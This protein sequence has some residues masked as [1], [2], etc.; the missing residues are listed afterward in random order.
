M[1]SEKDINK[2]QTF[3]DNAEPSNI[4]VIYHENCADGLG[5]AYAA[6][7]K[8]GEAATYLPYDYN[9]T[10][11]STNQLIEQLKGKDVVFSDVTLKRFQFL[12]VKENA[13][14]VLVLDHHPS[15]YNEIGDLD[16]CVF[17]MDRSGAMITWNSLNPDIKP[18]S[19]IKYIQD[20]D[21]WKFQYP[22]TKWFY[23]SLNK[24]N[25]TFRE[26]DNLLDDNLLKDFLNKGK[27]LREEYEAKVNSIVAQAVPVRFMGHD[28]YMVE[29]TRDY[30]SEVGNILALK[31]GSFSLCHSDKKDVY[32]ISVR[33][34]GSLDISNLCALFGGGG[35]P[36]A[37][38]FTTKDKAEFLKILEANKETAIPSKEEVLEIIKS[39]FE[40]LSLKKHKP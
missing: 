27:H 25:P 29:C 30:A 35:H 15:A 26:L 22:E 2:I 33:G 21:L 12:Q 34:N 17:D 38:A 5:S 39:R 7:K 20:G 18:P 31:S 40:T 36:N 16:C 11:E 3:V 10:E 28:I 32:K 9:K 6:W 23:S 19:F 1:N 13:K 24:F 14:S 37:S 4:F 8:F